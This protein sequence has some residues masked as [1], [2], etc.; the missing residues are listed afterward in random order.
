MVRS[1]C[2]A[3]QSHDGSH[4]QAL[5]QHQAIDTGS[6]EKGRGST[7]VFI[8]AVG[9]CDITGKSIEILKKETEP[10]SGVTRSRLADATAHS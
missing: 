7:G 5:T 10:G 6:H 1:H 8:I 3:L 2:A 9:E 4:R